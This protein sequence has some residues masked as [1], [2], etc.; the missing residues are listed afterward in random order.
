MRNLQGGCFMMDTDV[1][2]AC[3]CDKEEQVKQK[4]DTISILSGCSKTK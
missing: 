2:M 3:V 1:A 4:R